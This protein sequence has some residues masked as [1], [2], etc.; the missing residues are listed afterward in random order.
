M[1]A[2]KKRDGISQLFKKKKQNKHKYKETR[3]LQILFVVPLFILLQ[4]HITSTKFFRSHELRDG[5]RKISVL[6]VVIY[7]PPP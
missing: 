5:M 1:N 4:N 7:P 6:F 2:A 3:T